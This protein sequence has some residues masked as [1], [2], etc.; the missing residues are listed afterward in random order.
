MSIEALYKLA[1]KKLTVEELAERI[2]RQEELQ[3]SFEKDLIERYR[4]KECGACKF[5]GSHSFSCSQRGLS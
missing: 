2:R 4:C 5:N 3:A 1:N